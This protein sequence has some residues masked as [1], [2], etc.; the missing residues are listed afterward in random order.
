MIGPTPIGMVPYVDFMGVRIFDSWVHEQDVRRAVGRPGDR[1]GIGERIT[2]DRMEASMPYVLGRRVA[3][4]TGSTLRLAITGVLGR[5][6][7]L[8]M[9]TD[10]GGRGGRGPSRSFPGRPRP[11]SAWTRRPSC[12]GHA[13][14]SVPMPRSASPPPH[15]TAM[16]PSSPRSSL[17]WSS[18]S[19]GADSTLPAGRVR[20]PLCAQ[21]Q[22]SSKTTRSASPSK[23]TRTRSKLRSPALPRR[24]LGRCRSPGSARARHRAGRRGAHRGTGRAARRGA[25]RAASRLL[26]TG[27]RRRPR[28]SRSPSRSSNVTSGEEAGPVEFDA[29]VEVR[30]TVGSPGTARCGDDPVPG[31]DR[32]RLDLLSTAC[33]R[34][35]RSCVT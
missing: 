7:Q 23:S 10:E 18:W 22:N 32:R 28:S 19:D 24:S 25:A 29:V 33:A 4:A 31:R 3:P 12:A 15:G 8:E 11:R 2:L 35:T 6:I 26:R 30:P 13:G 16:R 14:G 20:D 9:S 17:R 21:H 1:G 27:G 34:R 5:V